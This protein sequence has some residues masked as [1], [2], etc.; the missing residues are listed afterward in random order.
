M[1]DHVEPARSFS[2]PVET[3]IIRRVKRLAGAIAAAVVVVVLLLVT[4][5]PR[6]VFGFRV[7]NVDKSKYV[8]ANEAAFRDVP[9]YAKLPLA[10]RSDTGIPATDGP[11]WNENGPPYDHYYTWHVYYLPSGRSC[12]RAAAF[13]K[14]TLPKRGWS[15]VG[16]FPWDASYVRGHA[17]VHVSCSRG[18]LGRPD[19]LLL[20]LDH[21]ER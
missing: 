6:H 4:V 18:T 21:D 14:T 16:G 7:T 11:P 5:R 10:N 19:A 9:V 8:A 1:H 20:S 15:W 2:S 12:T 3:T 13:Y 17:L